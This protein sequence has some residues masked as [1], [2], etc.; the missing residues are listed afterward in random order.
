MGKPRRFAVIDFP[1][2]CACL[3]IFA[4]GHQPNFAKWLHAR[5]LWKLLACSM[6]LIHCDVLRIFRRSDDWNCA[7]RRSCIWTPC[8]IIMH[9]RVREIF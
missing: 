5:I 9:F 7:R 3:Q 1:P 6:L 4:R 8:M 2:R